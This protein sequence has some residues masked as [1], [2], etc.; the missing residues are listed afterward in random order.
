VTAGGLVFPELGAGA[1]GLILIRAGEV[2]P[3]D[4]DGC[5]DGAC[6]DKRGTTTGYSRHYR[7]EGWPDPGPDCREANRAAAEAWR[8]RRRDARHRAPCGTGWPV[9]PPV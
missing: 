1:G 9:L 4:P 6:G 2:A 7:V 8:D 3:P 5:G